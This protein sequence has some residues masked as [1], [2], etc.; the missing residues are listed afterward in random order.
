MDSPILRCPLHQDCHSAK[1]AAVV[2]LESMDHKWLLLCRTR[3]L[4]CV[5]M[6]SNTQIHRSC[7]SSIPLSPLALLLPASPTPK[8]SYQSPPQEFGGL[9][10]CYIGDYQCSS[11]ASAAGAE[12]APVVYQ[13]WGVQTHFMEGRAIKGTSGATRSSLQCCPFRFSSL[14]SWFLACFSFLALTIYFIPQSWLLNPESWLA[15][16]FWLSH[17]CSPLSR[18]EKNKDSMLKRTQAERS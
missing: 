6:W 5:L 16:W 8:H 14:C 9:D 7:P 12:L 4:H 18:P 17:S 10:D 1:I 15:S 13:R 2:S 11:S 3:S